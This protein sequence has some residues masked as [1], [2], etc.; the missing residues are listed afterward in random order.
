MACL[1]EEQTTVALKSVPEW[2]LVKDAKLGDSIKRSF[3]FDD[4]Q[5]AFYFMTKTAQV[6]ETNQHHPNWSNLWNTVDVTL[7][8][9]DKL[10]LSTF[11]IE[12]AKAMDKINLSVQSGITR[13]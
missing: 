3:V 13:K 12:L 8:T 2:T 6:A 7:N 10:C 4:F 9:D 1:T 5:A 11:D